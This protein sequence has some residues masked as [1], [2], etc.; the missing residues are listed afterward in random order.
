MIKIDATKK[1]THEHFRGVA[2]NFVVDTA[3]ATIQFES[4]LS[5]SIW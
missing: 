3:M 4:H 2:R 5:A 1:K